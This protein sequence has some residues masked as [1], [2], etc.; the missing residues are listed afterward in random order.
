MTEEIYGPDRAC[1]KT[2]AADTREYVEQAMAEMALAKATN[3]IWTH[4]EGMIGKHDQAYWS[5]DE[6]G[7]LILQKTDRDD[8][9]YS[10]VTGEL[11][12]YQ[13]HGYIWGKGGKKH[14]FWNKQ[15]KY[16]EIPV[17]ELIPYPNH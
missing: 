3:Q 12:T 2:L 13:I 16:Y 4:T 15:H 7:P 8:H 6:E 9:R 10:L 5:A 14:E 11:G 17:S 1:K